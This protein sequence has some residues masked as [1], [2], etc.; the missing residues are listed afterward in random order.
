LPTIEGNVDYLTLRG[1][2][3]TMDES[4][5]LRDGVKSLMQ[6]VELVRSHGL[7]SRDVRAA[8]IHHEDQVPL[9]GND[10]YPAQ[11]EQY[12]ERKRRRTI[13]LCMRWGLVGPLRT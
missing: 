4:V 12:K 8:R 3:T 13:Y 1:Q 11:E 5:L 10:P 7:K 9:N 6:S 2:L